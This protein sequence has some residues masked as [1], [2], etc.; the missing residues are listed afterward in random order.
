MS[1]NGWIKWHRKGLDNPLFR[2][3]AGWH[4]WEYCCLKANH[5]PHQILFKGEAIVV[6]RGQ[7]LF[8]RHQAAQE[9][10]ISAGSIHRKMKTLQSLRMLS[11]Q[12][13]NKFS[14]ITIQN[15]DRYQSEIPGSEQQSEHQKHSDTRVMREMG[16]NRASN[17]AS[18]EQLEGAKHNGLSG[19]TIENRASNR[20]TNEHQVS[21]NKNDKK[22]KKKKKGS[23]KV[24]KKKETKKTKKSKKK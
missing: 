9:T 15:Y 24:E 22:D 16:Q 8:G 3:P 11:I 5:E 23:K 21:T 4:L 1:K 14:I 13:S 17:R 2:D 18:S 19:D 20:A 7:F 10:G 12:T 6:S